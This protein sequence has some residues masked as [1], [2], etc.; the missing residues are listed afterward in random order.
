MRKITKIALAVVMVLAVAIVFTAC[1]RKAAYDPMYANYTSPFGNVITGPYTE[2]PMPS[3]LGNNGGDNSGNG[4]EHIPPNDNNGNDPGNNGSGNNAWNNSGGNNNNN[5]GSGNNPTTRRAVPPATTRRNSPVAGTSRPSG[6]SSGNLIGGLP[7]LSGL[8][9]RPDR[10]NSSLE[11][12]FGG[13]IGSIPDMIK[14]FGGG[15]NNNS[16]G[17]SGGSNSATNNSSANAVPVDLSLTQI[18]TIY[19]D[20]LAKVAAD[21]PSFNKVSNAQLHMKADNPAFH[22]MG[23]IALEFVNREMRADNQRAHWPQTG[24]INDTLF[25]TRLGSGNIR[26]MYDRPKQSGNLLFL[27]IAVEDPSVKL[28]TQGN[29]LTTETIIDAMVNVTSGVSRREI[30]CTIEWTRVY[31]AI[32]RATGRFVA[33]EHDYLLRL[34][35][36]GSENWPEPTEF[37]GWLEHGYTNF[38]Y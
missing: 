7:D 35:A 12:S 1:R 27:D 19:N 31:C 4:E 15:G 2:P 36:Q 13:L 25:A 3:D 37:V 8:L 33:L 14:N 17:S 32:D 18:I 6:G 38:K 21:R 28:P 16:G 24:S 30:R 22:F 5:S 20:A 10:G 29:A 11:D 34:T 9:N 23:Q 26:G